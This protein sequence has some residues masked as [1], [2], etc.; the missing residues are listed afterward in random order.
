MFTFGS[1]IGGSDGFGTLF[2]FGLLNSKRTFPR[3]LDSNQSDE[4]E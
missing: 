4:G 3:V 1:G 2:A